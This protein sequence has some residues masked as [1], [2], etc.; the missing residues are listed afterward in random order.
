[1]KAT[2]S[3][4][5]A[6]VFASI[7]NAPLV[8]HPLNT[9]TNAQNAARRT[10]ALTYAT[11]LS[12]SKTHSPLNPAAWTRCLQQ[13]GL[14]HK[15]PSVSIGIRD[16]FH[17]GIPHIKC[18]YTLT[19]SPSVYPHKERFNDVVQYKLNMG[20]YIGSLT[21]AVVELLIGPFQSS[22]LSLIPKP[23]KPQSFRLIQ[24]FSHLYSNSVIPSINSHI[25]FNNYPY[26]W[27]TFN[28]ICILVWNLPAGSQA[29]IRDVIEAY[30]TIPLHTSQ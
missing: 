22:P 13:A 17:I 30:R 19:N 15:Y 27:R 23:H 25:D 12:Q 2:F 9:A 24:N 16:S 10:T 26:T 11:L 1:M 4:S 6:S 7:S 14:Q 21:R 18:M 8:V 5:K 28:T 3:T 20:W 29:A